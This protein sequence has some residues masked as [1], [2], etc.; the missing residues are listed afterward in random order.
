M[1]KTVTVCEVTSVRQNWTIRSNGR[2]IEGRGGNVRVAIVKKDGYLWIFLT[3]ED[4]LSPAPPFELVEQ[5]ALVCNIDIPRRV[6]I[7]S[8]VLSQMDLERQ[9]SLTDL[10]KRQGIPHN[11]ALLESLAKLGKAL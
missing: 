4:I 1:L 8:S 9:T 5:M 2:T 7:L 6:T 11:K 3:E 10:F